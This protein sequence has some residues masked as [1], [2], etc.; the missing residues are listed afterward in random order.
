VIRAI[1]D[2]PRGN[3]MIQVFGLDHGEL[4]GHR[5]RWFSWLRPLIHHVEQL[6]HTRDTIAPLFEEVPP[7]ERRK[8]LAMAEADLEEFIGDP[9]E[10]AAMI[11]AA[12]GARVRR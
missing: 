12:L 3:A 10:Y 8:D 5:L 4:D 2:N 11:R 6:I 9:A 1:D 7:P